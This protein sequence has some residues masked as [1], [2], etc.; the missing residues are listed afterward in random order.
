MHETS[1]RKAKHGG[2]CVK[3]KHKCSWEECPFCE[4]QVEWATHQCFI[5]P[6][7][8]KD[9]EPKLHKVHT[10][11]VGSRTVVRVDEDGDMWVEYPLLSLCLPTLRPSL[12]RKAYKHPSSCVSKMKKARTPSVSMGKAV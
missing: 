7:D 3:F 1:L 2:D 9:D 10:S 4:K 12:M 8:P 6:I 5:Q 11:Q